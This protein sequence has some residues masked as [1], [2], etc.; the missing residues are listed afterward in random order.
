MTEEQILL[1]WSLRPKLIAVAQR[2]LGPRP[3][4]DAEDCFMLVLMTAMP[5]EVRYVKAYFSSGVRNA[6]KSFYRMRKNQLEYTVSLDFVGGDSPCLVSE[7]GEVLRIEARRCLEELDGPAALEAITLLQVE[8]KHNSNQ[9]VRLCR[10]KAR[11]AR[12]ARRRNAA[13]TLW[14]I[15]QRAA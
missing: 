4:E 11:L 7:D 12:E 3:V 15:V 8:G 13:F 9:K 10:A 5:K 2:L 14:K 1:A 6:C